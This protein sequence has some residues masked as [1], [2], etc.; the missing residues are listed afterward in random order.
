MLTMAG[1]MGQAQAQAIVRGQLTD[2]QRQ[3]QDA[4]ASWY[5]LP[6]VQFEDDTPAITPPRR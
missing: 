2:Q 5:N 1:R 6:A 4:Q 3:A